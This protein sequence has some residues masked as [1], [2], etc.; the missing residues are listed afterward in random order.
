VISE[1]DTAMQ[2]RELLITQ[3]KE[4]QKKILELK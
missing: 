4:L 2:Q 3:N 1:V